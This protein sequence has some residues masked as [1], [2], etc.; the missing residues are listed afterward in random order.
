LRETGARGMYCARVS[1]AL[2]EAAGILTERSTEA[3]V[4]PAQ[5][6]PGESFGDQR[7]LRIWNPRLPGPRAE[8]G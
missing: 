5:H 3:T 8:P 7:L 6:V 2:E 4:S 1:R